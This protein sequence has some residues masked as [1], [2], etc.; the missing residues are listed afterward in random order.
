MEVETAFGPAQALLERTK[1]GALCKAGQKIVLLE[2]NQTVG[3]ALKSLAKNEILSAPMVINPDIEEVVGGGES[4]PQ[5]LGW[6]DVADV[7]RAFLQH[8]HDA[9]HKLPTQMLALMTLLEKEGPAF[10]DRLLVTIR[11]VEDRGLVYQAE[12]ETTSVA[13]AIRNVFLRPVDGETKVVHRLAVFDSHGEIVCV[14]SQTDVM[15]YLLDHLGEL[16][17]VADQT[18]EQLGMLTG[19]PP[20]LS[21]NPHVPALL[22]Y[23]QLAAQQVSGAPVVTDS[24]ELIANLSISDIRAITAEQFGALALPVAEFLAVEHGTAYLGYSARTS[25]HARHP[26]FASANRA[27]GPAKGDIQL[28]T[29]KASTTLRELLTKLVEQYIHR[30]YVVDQDDTPK[31]QAVITPT[32]IL[33]MVSGVA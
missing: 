19:K 16:G 10:S 20:V 18:L 8:L 11:G 5:L 25:D 13:D 9:G 27:G 1:L 14:V 28:F 29:V 26:F 4:S 7:L 15:R 2:H 31:V 12:G 30:V 22:A 32:D 33:R 21:V 23:A 3:E 17:S 6:I 24:G